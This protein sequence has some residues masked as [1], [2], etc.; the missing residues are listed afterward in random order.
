MP[1]EYINVLTSFCRMVRDIS[2][3]REGWREKEQSTTHSLCALTGDLGRLPSWVPDWGAVY[4]VVDRQR[5]ENFKYYNA[6][7]GSMVNSADFWMI[8]TESQSHKFLSQLIMYVKTDYGRLQEHCNEQRNFRIIWN[9]GGYPSHHG[10]S[11]ALV[12]GS[13]MLGDAVLGVS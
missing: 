8:E 7:L 13:A 10:R 1:R 5:D 9:K 6:T 11:D 3:M 4:D 12:G 2:T